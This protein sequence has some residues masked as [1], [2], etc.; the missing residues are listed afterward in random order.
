M[1]SLKLPLVGDAVY[2]G[3]AH[4]LMARQ[5]LHAEQLAFEHPM[6]GQALSFR[7]KLPVDFQNLLKAWSLSYNEKA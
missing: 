1:A 4:T 3:S 6:T 2:G 7:S 5:A